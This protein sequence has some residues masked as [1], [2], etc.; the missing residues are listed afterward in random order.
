MLQQSLEYMK[1]DVKYFAH[2]AYRILLVT[3]ESS[4]STGSAYAKNVTYMTTLNLEKHIAQKNRNV[5]TK[6]VS[7]IQ[8]TE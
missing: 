3:F 5:E 1:A 7:H 8:T 4:R 6:E 2:N